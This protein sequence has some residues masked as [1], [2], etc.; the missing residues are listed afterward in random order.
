V[1]EE[2]YHPDAISDA[3]YRRYAAYTVTVKMDDR[4]RTYQAI[5]LFGR[6]PDGAEA[7]WPIDHVL[8]MGSLN[9]VVDNSI[10]PQTAVGDTS[11]GVARNQRVDFHC[12]HQVGLDCA[13]R[14]LRRNHFQLRHP[15]Q[16]PAKG[17]A[18]SR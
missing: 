17:A 7:V 12:R 5:F 10:Y 6:H 13:R 9:Y 8:G 18:N 1:L 15:R 4:Q 3:V 16:G 11:S 2:F 14:S